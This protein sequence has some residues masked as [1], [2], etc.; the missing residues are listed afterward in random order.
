MNMMTKETF[1]AR[2]GLKARFRSLLAEAVFD[3]LLQ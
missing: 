2:K 3:I 1:G